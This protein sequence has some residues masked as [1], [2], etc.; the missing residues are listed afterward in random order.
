MCKI[1][2]LSA[3]CSSMLLFGQTLK[4]YKNKTEMVKDLKSSVRLAGKISKTNKTDKQHYVL[5]GE[6]FGLQGIICKRAE[7]TPLEIVQQAFETLQNQ[8]TNAQV[9]Y[10]VFTDSCRNMYGLY[11]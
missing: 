9:D 10:I 5:L 11:R 1:L 8:Q 4:P 7:I 6:A 3:L 2:L